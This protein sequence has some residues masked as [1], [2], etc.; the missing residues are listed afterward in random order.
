MDYR[1]VREETTDDYSVARLETPVRAQVGEPFVLGI[2]LRGFEDITLPLRIYRDDRLLTETTVP[3]IGGIGR[4][5]FTDRISRVGSYNYSAEIIPE[6]DAHPGNNRANRWIEITGGPRVLL[7]SKYENDPVA[8]VLR[9]QGFSVEIVSESLG[10]RIG[11]L[12]G[13]RA[14]IFNNVPAF[15]MPGE[16]LEALNFYVRE[17]GGGFM[18]VGG[19]QSFG[20][21][22]YFESAVDPLLPVSMELKSEHRKLAV[23]MAIVMDRS[24]SMS[25]TVQAGGGKQVSKMDLANAGAAKAIEL[26]GGMDKICVYAVDSEPHEILRLTTVGNQKDRWMKLVRKV[27]S[28]GGGISRSS[29]KMGPGFQAPRSTRA[30]RPAGRMRGVLS[31]MPPPVMC[32]APWSRLASCSRRRGF[33]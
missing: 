21:G 31:V 27:Q 28:T 15:E 23:A 3:I 4:T 17:Q 18:M 9:N 29:S 6:N 22:G 12:S 32:A 30:S 10:L 16:F 24:G 13:T 33:R 7:V 8:T 19:K 11:Q 25:M 26:L 1:L 20:S 5:E 14:V 2:T